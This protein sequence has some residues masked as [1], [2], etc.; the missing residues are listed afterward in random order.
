MPRLLFAATLIVG[1]AWCS[2]DAQAGRV[3]TFEILVD[4]KLVLSANT[5]DQGEPAATAWNYLKKLPLR[6]PSTV[7]VLPP[8]EKAR[9]TAFY[10][11]LDKQGAKNA[12]I[13]GECRIF[14]RYAGDVTVDE[15]RLV[16]KDAKSPWYIDPA[17]VDELAKRRRVDPA[18][19]TREQVDGAK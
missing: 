6:N 3:V 9:M 19:L 16:R 1:S 8:E 15:L 10:A 14:C 17:Q 11:E 18:K 7:W 12:T 4:G 2:Q 13:E 5:L